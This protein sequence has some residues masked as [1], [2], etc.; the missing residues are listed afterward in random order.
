MCG[1][2]QLWYHFPETILHLS[3]AVAIPGQAV[4]PVITSL[5]MVS[6]QDVY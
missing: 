4:L 2:V 6:G 5:Y 3:I 1:G